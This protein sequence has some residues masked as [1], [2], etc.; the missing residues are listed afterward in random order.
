MLFL[1]DSLSLILLWENN[2]NKLKTN[3]TSSTWIFCIQRG[4]I[5]TYVYIDIPNIPSNYRTYP[6]AQKVCSS[7]LLVNPHL[8]ISSVWFDYATID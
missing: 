2:S 6:L 8:P 4:V 1:P 3:F 5:L 7:G